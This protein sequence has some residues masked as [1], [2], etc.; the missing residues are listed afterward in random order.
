VVIKGRGMVSWNSLFYDES[1]TGDGFR[2]RIIMAC[3][4]IHVK[5]ELRY[6]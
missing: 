2:E 6:F 3:G 5:D 4:F 1:D